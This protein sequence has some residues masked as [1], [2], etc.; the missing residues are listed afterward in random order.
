MKTIKLLALF[1]SAFVFNANSFAAS[2][3]MGPYFGTWSSATTYAAGNVVTYSSSTYLSLVASNKN[4]IPSASTSAAAWQLIGG[5]GSAGPAGAQGIQGVAG[6]AY[7]AKAGDA[8]TLTGTDVINSGTLVSR[9]LSGVAKLVCEKPNVWNFQK[10][11]LIGLASGSQ[12]KNWTLM[13]T[14]VV[15]VVAPA[16]SPIYLSANFIQLPTLGQC[17]YTSSVVTPTYVVNY[18]CWSNGSIGDGAIGIIPAGSP[19]RAGSTYQAASEVDLVALSPSSVNSSVVRWTSPFAGTVAY[20]INSYGVYVGPV[21]FSYWGL[22]H[23]GSIVMQKTDLTTTSPLIINVAVG[24]T[25]DFV[26]EKTSATNLIGSDIII[27]KQ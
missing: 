2:I 6:P 4:K 24:D 22:L 12:Y 27:T 14:P 3:A 7:V 8:C 10:D 26:Y 13:Y 5:A 16:T 21:S 9:T 18:Q 20:N 23:N 25:L 15:P 11:M 1:L 17:S 19:V